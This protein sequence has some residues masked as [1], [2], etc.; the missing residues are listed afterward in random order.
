[1]ASPKAA[2]RTCDYVNKAGTKI[3]VK[4]AKTTTLSPSSCCAA[5]D[6]PAQGKTTKATQ[7]TSA[8]PAKTNTA[9]QHT[10]KQSGTGKGKDTTD[11]TKKAKKPQAIAASSRSAMGKSGKSIV[12][13]PLPCTK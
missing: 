10:K 1:V 12:A 9:D 4:K 8:L 5:V 3:S 11:S 6:R 7:G 13:V 2:K